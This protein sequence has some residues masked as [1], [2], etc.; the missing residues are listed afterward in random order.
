MIDLL[1]LPEEIR[2]PANNKS[3]FLEITFN[4]TL[5]GNLKKVSREAEKF[6]IQEVLKRT[7]NNKT[8]T[9]KILGVDRKTLYNK[10]KIHHISQT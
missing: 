1:C 3:S 4:G 9:A 6:A 7:N 10:M 5:P 2:E 8:E